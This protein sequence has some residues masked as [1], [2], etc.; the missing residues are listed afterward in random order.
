MSFN[1]MTLGQTV[2]T[3]T[4]GPTNSQINSRLA[5]PGVTITGGTL[6]HGN[7]NLQ[8]ALFQGGYAAGLEIDQGVFFGTGSNQNILDF[9]S[10]G[11]AISYDPQYDS[12]L[13]RLAAD[14]TYDV[15]S[16][17]F[18]V[19]I[20]NTA[21]KLSI[22]Y[23]FGSKEYPE[24]V[25]TEYNDVFGFFVSGPGISGT[26]NLAKLPNGEPT[27]INTVN[28]N[29]QSQ[30]FINN[31]AYPRPVAVQ[32]D[33]I[34]KAITFDITDLIPGEIYT[35]KIA[36][37]DVSD[38]L[39]DSGV[40]IK[41]VF[42]TADTEANDDHYTTDQGSTTPTVLE[43]DTF[44]GGAATTSNVMVSGVS[45]P[46]G[47]TLNSD[48]TISVG[49]GVVPGNYEV[50][51]Q[52]CDI[53]NSTSCTT[54]TAYITVEEAECT[55]GDVAPVLG[56]ATI[57]GTTV[58]L[59]NMFAG[60]LPDN[61][62]LEWHT[63]ATPID[64]TTLVKS[65]DVVTATSTPT[66]Y[67]AVFHSITGV[68]CYSPS[69]KVVVVSNNCPATTV[70]LTALPHSELPDNT[71]LKWFTV[72]N[73]DD[74]DYLVDDP[75][76]VGEGTYW[77][78]IYDS[79]AEC[80]SPAGTP[81]VV[82]IS[83]C[84]PPYCYKPGIFDDGNALSTNVGITSLG[85]AGENNSDQWPMVRKGGWLALESPTK[86][87][88]PNR[89]AFNNLTGNPVGFTEFVE[90]MMVYDTTNKCMKMYTSIDDGATFGWYCIS[91][92]TCPPSDED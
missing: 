66:N 15:V 14:E 73:S 24:F 40:F 5:G 74:E 84:T 81:V 92:Q 76:Q 35:F 29:E 9:G 58:N 87:F 12:D 65:P 52:I 10:G 49:P 54:A 25:G 37:A 33:G 2:V 22:T 86:G 7:R 75:T 30:L 26:Q 1:M 55:A 16:Y 47:F 46:S 57:S 6:H 88:V 44:N 3:Y 23:Q 41:S 48:G 42:A 27:S 39:F 38:E 80:Y 51:Y 56:E 90:G 69:A 71:E 70:D 61:T 20:A 79:A 18:N 36:I 89:V 72:P 43:N 60:T 32:L 85:R 62:Q 77:P 21:T 4:P 64:D 45:V 63:T 78:F 59:D 19:K 11:G 28:A 67:Y 34:T 91:Q 13:Q 68:D 17:S 50:E 83:I 31:E 82:G 53:N 8:I